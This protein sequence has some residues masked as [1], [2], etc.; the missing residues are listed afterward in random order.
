[1]SLVDLQ[2]A[3]NGILPVL[4]QTSTGQ[5]LFAFDDWL[6]HDGFVTNCVETTWEELSSSTST[7]DALMSS[8][9]GDTYVRRAVY[10][11]D[12]SFLLRFYVDDEDMISGVQYSGDFDLT[13]NAELIHTIRAACSTTGSVLWREE[14]AK[15]F[16]DR[17][18]V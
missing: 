4:K 17:R 18:A 6:Q 14:A 11:A 16:F 15:D 12:C 5:A 1:M 10:P 7:I 9:Q 2:S 3:L 13:A 8:R